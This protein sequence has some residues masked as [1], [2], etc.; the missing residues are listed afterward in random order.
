[1]IQFYDYVR[2]YMWMGMHDEPANE[3]EALAIKLL[4]DCLEPDEE[5]FLDAVRLAVEIGGEDALVHFYDAI[6]TIHPNIAEVKAAALSYLQG[7]A[8]KGDVYYT[9]RLPA[10]GEYDKELYRTTHILEQ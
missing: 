3:Y 7:D 6:T 1:M 8:V 5:T 9:H 10:D 2:Y 4:D